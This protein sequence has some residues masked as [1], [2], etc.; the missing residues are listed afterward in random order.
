[1]ILFSRPSR[2]TSWLISSCQ[3][4]RRRATDVAVVGFFCSGQSSHTSVARSRA[5]CRTPSAA[6]DLCNRASANHEHLVGFAVGGRWKR[7]TPFGEKKKEETARG[8]KKPPDQFNEALRHDVL[9]ILQIKTIEAILSNTN[10]TLL[11]QPA[12]SKYLT[13]VSLYYK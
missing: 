2:S 9:Q 13:P 3:A 4:E 11:N 1:M 5:I 7:E 6:A 10:V 8:R 12:A